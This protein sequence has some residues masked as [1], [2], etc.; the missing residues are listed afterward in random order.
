MQLPARL[1]W[2][3]IKLALEKEDRRNQKTDQQIVVKRL[4]MTDQFD[5]EMAEVYLYDGA[6][7]SKNSTLTRGGAEPLG[8]DRD[9]TLNPGGTDTATNFTTFAGFY[10]AFLKLDLRGQYRVLLDCVDGTYT[11]RFT[12]R[13]RPP[14]MIDE[15][16]LIIRGN[17]STP[18]SCVISTTNSCVPMFAGAWAQMEGFK[19]TASAVAAAFQ[20]AECSRLLHQTN[21]FGT[22]AVGHIQCAEGYSRAVGPYSVTG[23]A[24]YHVVA[25]DRGFYDFG[26]AAVTLTGV[27]NYSLAFVTVGEDSF[28]DV[29]HSS[30]DTSGATVTGIKYLAPSVDCI[31]QP[32]GTSR[33]SLPGDQAGQIV[34]GLGVSGTPASPNNG[35]MWVEGSSLKIRLGGVTKTVTVT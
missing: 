27:Q 3:S 34:M 30:F 17:I 35:D 14:G 10:S 19:L 23:G 6:L 7:Y 20:L 21:D 29:N 28:L 33:D 11:E 31:G 1:D 5:G 18:D 32:G 9:Y 4:L 12:M 15:A 26:N 25:E 22:C 13:G 24:P 16:A 2:N 8:S